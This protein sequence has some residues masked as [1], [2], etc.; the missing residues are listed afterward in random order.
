[1]VLKPT[2]IITPRPT[3]TRKQLL[4][5]WKTKKM[6]EKRISDRFFR[7]FFAWVGS[8]WSWIEKFDGFSV[9]I[10]RFPTKRLPK[11][12]LVHLKNP[13]NRYFAVTDGNT[14]P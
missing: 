3:N 7:S 4:I 9:N 12:K 8:G 10:I 5:G 1:M 2:N 13:V 14:T 6:V 11:T